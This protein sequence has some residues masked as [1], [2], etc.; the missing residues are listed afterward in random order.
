MLA[1]GFDAVTFL[2]LR[3]A[4][5]S[6]CARSPSTAVAR[7]QEPAA[8]QQSMARAIV[9]GWRFVGTTPMVR[10]LVVGILGAFAAG[11]AVVGVGRQFARGPARRRRRLRLC[12]SAPS[13]PVSPSACWSAPGCCAGSARAASSACPSSGAGVT[14]AVDS[15]AAQPRPRRR[16]HGR[17][18][19]LR[20]AGL[21]DRLHPARRR[22]ARRRARPHLLPRPVAGP[23]RPAAHAVG[24]ARSSRPS[25]ATTAAARGATRICAT[26]A[27]RAA[28]RRR[29]R[30]RRRRHRGV[31]AD[32]RPARR[33][34]SGPTCGRRCGASRRGA[35]RP[36]RTVHRLRGRRGRRQV[37]PGAAARR[38]AR[39]PRPR[40][41][42]HPRARRHTGRHAAARAA[43]R[44]R[45]HRA[46][47]ARRGAALRRRPG[48]ARRRGGAARAGRGAVVVT[49]RYIDSSVAYQG[50]GRVLPRRRD[51]RAL[52]TGPPAGCCPS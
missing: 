26:T 40:G 48:R 16:G 41:G 7:R 13:S 27:S 4:R 21:G 44:P 28:V 42:H 25:S 18:R 32:G 50:A 49:D 5:S 19:L 2:D 29:P 10:G 35:R 47:A 20:R 33:L 14:L 34:A 30:R 46:V 12:C 6:A 22:G 23:G 31:P 52:R 17:R 11:G 24:R 3:A 15:V 39:R 45:H 8:S 43:A 37:D 1:F 36:D 38:V 51:P 9:D